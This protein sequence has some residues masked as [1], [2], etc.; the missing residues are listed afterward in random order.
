MVFY[1]K[2]ISD[3]KFGNSRVIVS[4]TNPSLIIELFK[5]EVPEIANNTVEIKNVAR[6]PG[7][8]AKIAVYSTQG[9][10]DPVGAC[11]GQ[12]GVRVQTVTNELD[13]NEKIDIIQWNK[14]RSE[15][16]R[17]GKECRSRWSPYH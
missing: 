4:R 3:D 16:R 11:V 5:K 17:V 1:I 6:E 12:R 13:G 8:R 10:V 15:E 14:D 2:E 9:G 7:E